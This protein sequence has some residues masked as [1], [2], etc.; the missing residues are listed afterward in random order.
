[1]SVAVA[2]LGQSQG[3]VFAANRATGRIALEVGVSHGQT[4]RARVHEDGSL[5]VRFP[6]AAPAAPL[7]AVI[8]NTAGGMA[9]GDRF[10]SI[11]RSAPARCLMAGTA[12]AEKIYRSLGAMRPSM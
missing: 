10:G 4:R 9:G 3:E 5:R 8:V 11:S 2:E 12:A 7:E 6:N 1:M